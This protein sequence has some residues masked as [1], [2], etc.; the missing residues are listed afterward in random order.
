MTPAREPLREGPIGATASGA[1]PKHGRRR[2]DRNTGTGST[3]TTLSLPFM[4]E[5]V[6]TAPSIAVAA[7]IANA[8][9]AAVS[10][11]ASRPPDDPA[12]TRPGLAFARTSIGDE[13]VRAGPGGMPLHLAR[14]LLL[15]EEPQSVE[16]LRRILDADWLPDALLELERR[17]LLVRI[18]PPAQVARRW[19]GGVGVGVG[20]G[21]GASVDVDVEAFGM[22]RRRVRDAFMRSIGAIDDAM[23]Q[24]IDRCRS[25][26]ELEQLMPQVRSLLRAVAGTM[27][28]ARF[29]SACS[30]EAAPGQACLD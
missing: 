27:V 5:A 21:V 14:L 18:A 8:T 17:R 29:E 7:T 2:S 1:P 19:R 13:R 4:H 11:R 28:T 25:A 23:A 12:P 9:N 16:E 15:F 10:G 20:V 22:Y 3:N 6:C 30:R 24:R 26:G